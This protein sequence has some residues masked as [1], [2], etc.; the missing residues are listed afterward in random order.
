MERA[1]LDRSDH[2]RASSV[3]GRSAHSARSWNSL[4]PEEQEL[5]SGLQSRRFLLESH[6]N[7]YG[8]GSDSSSGKS[9][10]R[11]RL[12]DAE[13]AE[14]DIASRQ[15]QAPAQALPPSGIL[16]PAAAPSTADSGR[17]GKD[18]CSKA[19]SGSPGSSGKRQPEESLIRSLTNSSNSFQSD[20]SQQATG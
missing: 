11:D 8:A 1:D 20:D 15:T 13:A 3:S 5:A 19:R 7:S 16:S 6:A 10:P 17:S 2:S 9:Q 12:Q 18:R 4:S 14:R